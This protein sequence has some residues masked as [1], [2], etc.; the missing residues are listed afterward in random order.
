MIGM[1]GEINYYLYNVFIYV[2]TT[3]NKKQQ[4]L[5]FISF[6]LFMFYV[7]FGNSNIMCVSIY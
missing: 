6:F 2:Y 7:S 4:T 1:M 3:I 5:I